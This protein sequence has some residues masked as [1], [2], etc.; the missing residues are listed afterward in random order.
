MDWGTRLKK[1][2]THDF[3]LYKDNLNIFACAS[4][5]QAAIWVLF[6]G[7]KMHIDQ[8]DWNLRDFQ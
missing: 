7:G 2:V 8:T 4:A 3:Y 6:C 5:L 1:L